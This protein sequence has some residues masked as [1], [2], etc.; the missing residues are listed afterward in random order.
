MAPMYKQ[1]LTAEEKLLSDAIA[2]RLYE[3]LVR[4]LRWLAS[5]EQIRGN[6]LLNADDIVGECYFVIVKIARSYIY[7]PYEEAVL[8]CK[9][10]AHNAIGS[11]KHRVCI[12][13][14]K[15]EFSMHSLEEPV[16]DEED[17]MLGEV[18]GEAENAFG[19]NYSVNPESW[20]A[21]MEEFVEKLEHLSELDLRVL[22]ALLGYDENTGRQLRL[23]RA[24]RAFVYKDAPVTVTPQLVSRAMGES[25]EAVIESYENIRRVLWT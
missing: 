15:T 23:S 16:S 18:I 14:R 12:S 20:V 6:W 1:P 13:H 2:I 17:M 10:S 11:L 3:D 25:L 24:R 7:K 19:S 22:A 8:V 21:A 9:A 4:W 5:T